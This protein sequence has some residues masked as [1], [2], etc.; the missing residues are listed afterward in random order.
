M[1]R[2]YDTN[3]RLLGNMRNN[4]PDW[5]ANCHQTKIQVVFHITEKIK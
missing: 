2:E 3:K 4:P 5:N 1:L